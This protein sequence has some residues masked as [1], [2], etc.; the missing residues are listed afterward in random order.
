M[1]FDDEPFEH[2]YEIKVENCEEL[3][4]SQTSQHNNLNHNQTQS[5]KSLIS[6]SNIQWDEFDTLDYNTQINDCI[7]PNV[8]NMISN[9]SALRKS[10]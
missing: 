3:M 4:N 10:S 1:M 7:A 9:S 8:S 2:N 5:K 6:N